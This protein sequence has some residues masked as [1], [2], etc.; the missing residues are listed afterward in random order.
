[1]RNDTLQNYTSRGIVKYHV[2]HVV[3]VELGT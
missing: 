1:M 3:D 2:P